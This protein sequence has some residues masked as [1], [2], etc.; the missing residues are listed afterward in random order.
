V[1]H[2]LGPSHLTVLLPA[3]NAAHLLPGWLDSV[4]RHADTIIALDDGS[5]D[6]TRTVLE[7]HRGVA[8]VLANP[9]R[10]SY[11]G[12]DDLENRQRLVHAAL[13]RGAS[14]LLFLD[15]DESLDEGDW[16]ALRSFLAAEAQPGFAYGFQVFR[17]IEEVNEYDPHSLWVF[18]L[19]SADDAIHPLGSQ[20]LHFVPVPSKIQRRNWLFTSLRIRHVSSMTLEHRS[21]RFQKYLEADPDN[22][23]QSDYTNLL[24]EPTLVQRWPERQPD[25]PVLLGTE[26]RYA[27]RHIQSF[28]PDSPAL[29]AVV[30]AQDDIDRIGPSLDALVSQDLD[31]PFEIIVICSGSDGTYELA[32]DHSPM[33]RAV[34]LPVRALPGEAR[35]AGLWMARGD[36]VSFPGSH[37]RL[38]PD[39]LSERLRTH[40]DGWDMVA[41]SVT[42]GNTTA[43]GW[44]SYI[45]DHAT[46][47]PERPEGE[48]TG[49]PGSASYVTRDVI[50]LGGFPPD[51][52]TGEDTAV[53]SALHQAGRRT[54]FNPRISFIHT[55]PSVTA[56]QLVHHHFQRGRALGRMIRQRYD[57]PDFRQVIT[58]LG[59][60]KRRLDT[61][62]RALP[63][64]GEQVR[65]QYRG[66]IRLM[67]AA[68]ALGAASG[69]WFELLHRSSGTE[70]SVKIP[71][72]PAAPS[73]PWL[74]LSGR[75]GEAG[76]GLLAAGRPKHAAQQ[77]ATLSRYARSV[78]DVRPV[79]APIVTSAMLT[80]ESGGT[81]TMDLRRSTAAA[82][83]G[84]ARDAGVR[85]ALQ[86]QPG[87]KE[88]LDIL[89]GWSDL[90]ADESVGVYFDLRPQLAWNDQASQ[91]KA[92]VAAL[93]RRGS[94]PPLVLVR[95]VDAVPAGAIK[96]DAPLDLRVPGTPYP[97]ELFATGARPDVVVYE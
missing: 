22:E 48:F 65:G 29:S 1:G 77:L 71:P 15:A 19:F 21:E 51:V 18:R 85:L 25:L 6:D 35:N 70:S 45:L 10:S 39:A 64:A 88:L 59:L 13:S 56:T 50:G 27:D 7:E 28:D 63:L 5:T 42:N 26:G 54:Y 81:F 47:T 62:N 24:S 58:T 23:F 67:V 12:W 95:G 93:S 86:I 72:E 87:A 73:G 82:F 41:G 8:H 78:C 46:K 94:D 40:E 34:Q 83:A 43:A 61:I 2:T 36:Y 90:V 60:P 79:L 89:N 20:R 9:V 16:R 4:G 91:L 80:A 75:P 97:H 3:R 38:L 11:R 17:M 55:S 44:A 33:V 52:R 69:A 53:N 57:W 96:V 14:W 66:Q 49:V 30:I 31:D 37:I 32:R 74:I 76:H 92:V 84:S 68:G